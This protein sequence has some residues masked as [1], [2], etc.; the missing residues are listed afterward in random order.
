MKDDDNTNSVTDALVV[1]APNVGGDKLLGARELRL[2]EPPSAL[3]RLRR[4]TIDGVLAQKLGQ[5]PAR[6]TGPLVLGPFSIHD[7]RTVAE[8]GLVDPQDEV[9]VSFDRWKTVR[10]LFPGMQEFT[11]DRDEF[12]QTATGTATA[13]E[14]L[15]GEEMETGA[16]GTM[17]PGGAPRAGGLGR[18]TEGDPTVPVQLPAVPRDKPRPAAVVS[19]A[20]PPRAPNP[21]PELVPRPA[22]RS[23]SSVTVALIAIAAIALG[24]LLVGGKVPGSKRATD[25]GISNSATSVDDRK[26][27]IQQHWPANLKPRP[28]AVLT[29]GDTPLMAKL[30]PILSDYEKGQLLLEPARRETLR[31]LSD[32]ASGS[33]EVRKVAANQ[34]AVYMLAQGQAA[35]A[36][37]LLRPILE[38]A[39]TDVVTLLN[40]ALV[41]LAED[42]FIQAR[43][44]AGAAGL[45]CPPGL[46]WL[47]EAVQGMVEGYSAHFDAAEPHFRRAAALSANNP[48]VPG[49]WLQS[50]VRNRMTADTRIA[51]LIR[52]TLLFDPDR[53][54]DSPIPAPIAGHV[55]VKEAAAGFSRSSDLTIARLSAGQK[56]FVRWLEGRVGRNPLN[57]SLGS[58]LEQLALESDPVSQVLYAYALRDRGNLEQA[59]QVLARV[60]PL[61]DSQKG[62]LSS[63]WPWTYSGDV[64]FAL[65]Q[66]DSAVMS[67]QASQAR[68]SSDAGAFLGMALI[69]RE[70]G[71]FA[72]SESQLSEALRADPYFIPAVLRLSRFEWQGQSLQR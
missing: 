45:H 72:R 60:L 43:Q 34:L 11:E 56:G 55:I 51:H 41:S 29:E 32:P 66:Y 36:K 71:D 49:L 9:L 47:T 8:A 10:S 48:V 64:Q 54:L 52:D 7:I 37:N 40:L 18:E 57:Q 68:N 58:V 61:L 14:S 70:K 35:E 63:S 44:Y 53:L 23:S 42:D 20:P 25:E 69:F 30:R 19:R 26:E 31:A 46:C 50:F 2:R 5:E 3:L 13:T 59:S 16:E 4:G 67:Y 22:A 33:F 1:E 38:A 15:F 17:M 65:G 21:P 62:L 39:R 28:L 24:Y 6:A 27:A 12:T